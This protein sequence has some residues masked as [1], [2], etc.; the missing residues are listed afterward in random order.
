MCRARGA[1]LASLTVLAL[2]LTALGRPVR[3]S[4]GRPD[5]LV[6]LL[7]AA[8]ADHLGA[9][10]QPLP[11][12]PTLDL[13]ARRGVQLSRAYAQSTHTYASVGTLLSGLLPDQSKVVYQ[14]TELPRSSPT[15]PELL[16]QQGYF[17]A[18]ISCNP[19]MS[20]RGGFTRGFDFFKRLAGRPPEGDREGWYTTAQEMN[21][22]LWRIAGQLFSREPFFVYLHYLPPHNPYAPPERLEAAFVEENGSTIDGSTRT[23]VDLENSRRPLAPA[24]LARLR[25]LYTANLRAADRGVAELLQ[26]LHLTG[27]LNR[28]WLIVLADHGEAFREHGHLL[29]CTTVYEEMARVPLIVVPPGGCRPR[30]EPAPVGIVDL[31]PTIAELAGVAEPP[32][33]LAGRSLV[34]TLTGSGQGDAA[35]GGER[36][37]Y[38]RVRYALYERALI[39][40]RYKLIED[41]R[42]GRVRLYDLEADPG[43]RRDVAARHPEVTA[44]YRQWLAEIPFLEK[45][46][47]ESEDGGSPAEDRETE[48]QLRALGYAR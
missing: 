21:R 32:S 42:S 38:S 5:I 7:D 39:G 27:V 46:P 33:G 48:E 17:T 35:E 37:Q 9:W 28:T 30:I 1:R 41:R 25:A 15:L 16:R 31:Y 18:A 2:L 12:T 43:E 36:L 11:A 29:H 23:L 8:R 34:S 4:Q 22:L 40:P 44:R 10:G 13:L 20:R 14:W 45:K 24:D 3:A 26:L 6:V 47:P 19:N